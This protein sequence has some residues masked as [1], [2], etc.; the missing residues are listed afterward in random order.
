MKSG[1][2]VAI[3]WWVAA[4]LW[5]LA[6]SQ[7]V[8]VMFKSE[9]AFSQALLPLFHTQL[10]QRIESAVTGVGIPDVY[11]YLNRELWL[12]LKNDPFHSVWQ[13]EWTIDW[14]RGQQAWAQ[15]YRKQSGKC[16]YTAVALKNG[17]LVI[18]M[19]KVFNKKIVYQSDVQRMTKI[20]DVV[21]VLHVL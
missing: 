1:G 20:E 13:Q 5:V 9:Q 8:L 15:R 3:F 18:P 11:L 6:V 7:G 2:T 4:V 14:R 17:F 12:E 10:C 16:V 21:E 19:I